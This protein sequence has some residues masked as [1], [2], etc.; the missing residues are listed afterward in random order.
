MSGQPCGCDPEALWT[1]EQH[2]IQGQPKALS[3]TQ[4][5]TGMA[6]EKR[7]Q[8]VRQVDPKTGGEKGS[9]LARFALVPW[10]A[11]WLVAEHFGRG[12]RKYADRN[13]E[14]GYKW[15]LSYDA[16]MRHFV[17]DI[18][19]ED[20]DDETGS[21]HIVAVAWHALVLISFRLLRR[22]TDDRARRDSEAIKIIKGLLPLDVVGAVPLAKVTDG[23]SFHESQKQREQRSNA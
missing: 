12:A 13:W 6:A 19:G 22:G 4:Q 18:M 3:L 10:E 7:G 14:R 15:S 2:R 9:K 11:I 5:A 20:T 8:E 1:C 16:L 23:P 17:L 21:W